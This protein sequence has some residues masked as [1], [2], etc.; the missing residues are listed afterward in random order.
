MG[1]VQHQYLSGAAEVTANHRRAYTN[2]VKIQALFTAKNVTLQEVTT[3]HQGSADEML[4]YFNIPS[5]Y[6]VD[7]RCKIYCLKNIRQ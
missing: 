4:V 1:F 3:T 6:T 7:D 5:N 2:Y